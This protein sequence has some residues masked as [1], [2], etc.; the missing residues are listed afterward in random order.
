[1]P[2]ELLR[3]A[4]PA[5][6]ATALWLRLHQEEGPVGYRHGT[7]RTRPPRE[8]LARIRPLA[9]AAGITRL[10][11]VTGLDTVGIRTYQAV[12]P[13]SHNITIS[14][15]KGLTRDQARV[16]ALMEALELFHAERVALPPL[17]ATVREV[18]GRLSYDPYL[19]P[20]VHA[21]MGTFLPRG[22]DPYLLPREGTAHLH[23]DLPL[24]WVEAT[25]LG[26]G[27]P[28]LLP[29]ALCELDFRVR[30]R[31]SLPVFRA[32]SNGLASGNTLAEALLHALCEVVERDSAARHAPHADDPAHQVDP[33]TV[34]SA[35]AHALLARL[36]EA[37]LHPR[38]VDATGPTGVPC[39]EVYLQEHPGAPR[40]YGAG[41]HPSRTT[42]LLR[43]LTEAAQTRLTAIAGSRD[44][45]RPDGYR[46]M[47]ELAP[48][49]RGAR[50]RPGRD[51][52]RVPSLR[53]RT[54]A[55]LV[56]E[57][58][59]RVRAVAGAPPVAAD[60][61]RPEFGVPV[62]FVV[63]PGFGLRLHGQR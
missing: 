24:E 49:D 12:R 51:F 16:S 41:C 50:P 31:L 3:A 32:T 35:R 20:L 57:I 43:A 56:R 1:M 27:T 61:S 44:D 53:G 38:M 26:A 45:L 2:P 9:A 52:R 22:V 54:L 23:D 15:G 33:E 58:A 34:G 36:S 42:A 17:R 25:E 18:R 4:P 40:F 47:A 60:L 8:T 11:D 55:G 30:E 28:T 14:M 59:G 19:L 39:M 6:G 48:P 29:R 5:A 62:V 13:A 7:W 37:G 10:A 63:V 21:G 46:G